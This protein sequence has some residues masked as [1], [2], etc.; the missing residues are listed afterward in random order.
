MKFA[1]IQF[2]LIRNAVLTFAF[3]VISCITIYGVCYYFHSL[4][5]QRHTDLANTITQVNYDI[6]DRYTNLQTYELYIDR[7]N[8]IKSI[9]YLDLGNRI[10]WVQRLEET[11]E[12]LK[13][14]QL[15]YKID[16]TIVSPVPIN[17]IESVDIYET[18]IEVNTTVAHEGDIIDLYSDLSSAPG[19]GILDSKTCDI[20]RDNNNSEAGYKPLKISCKF[21]RYNGSTQSQNNDDVILSSLNP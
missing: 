6:T 5:Q 18:L 7:F 16:P 1:N 14:Q 15:D 3:S 9:G 17:R 20:S 8:E 2:P 10:D 19:M 4:W 13:L 21:V 11:A 12:K